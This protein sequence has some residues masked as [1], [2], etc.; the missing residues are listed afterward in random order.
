[1]NRAK[2][3]ISLILSISVLMLQVGGVFAAPAG[4]DS[5]T[6][7]VHRITLD[8]D[9]HTGVT[10]VMVE[11]V[12]QGQG[13]QIVRVSEETA[14]G[15]GLATLDVDG[16]VI[17]EAALGTFIEID[18]EDVIPSQ[19]EEHH[20]VANALAT[21][22]A[23]IAEEE[24]LYDLIVTAHHDGMGFGVIAQALWLT[25]QI[26]GGD[27]ADFQALLLAK[28][29]GDYSGFALED[30]S[31]PRNWAE[32]R[33][34]ISAGEKLG[35]LGTVMKENNPSMNAPGN[36]NPDKEKGKEPQKGNNG[37][38]GNSESARDREKNK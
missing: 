29:S 35:N 7:R 38:G 12:G 6:G 16:P 23:G 14:I 19:A 24:S 25:H 31:T 20:P 18:P 33:K 34:A 2:F 11:L 1:M 3:L 36:D 13:K 37:N 8:T 5:I 10:F 28:Q 17:N 30:G 15:L 9:S 26:P 22:F 27:E 4:Q 21:F 32:L